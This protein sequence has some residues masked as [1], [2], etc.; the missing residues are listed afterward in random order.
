MSV[1]SIAGEECKLDSLSTVV[2]A[3]G[4]DLTKVDPQNLS[5]DFANILSQEVLATNVKVTVNLHKDLK[6]RNQDP[7]FV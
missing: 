3:T 4:G 7:E 1:I 5:N 6:F 2:E